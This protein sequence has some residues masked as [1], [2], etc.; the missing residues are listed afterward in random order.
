MVQDSREAP[1]WDGKHLRLPEPARE[2]ISITEVE[3][4]D[5]FAGPLF[6]R[7]FGDPPPAL[8]HH[9]VAFGRREDASLVPVAYAHF[10][11]FGDIALIGGMST[12]G[13][14]LTQLAQ[15]AREAVSQAGGLAL[16]LLHYGFARFSG[17]SAFFGHVGDARAREVDLKAGFRDTQHEH[18][19]VY[20][21]EVLPEWKQKAL[22]AKARSI[23]PF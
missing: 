19:M 4:G 13:Q 17:I 8:P 9:I 7:K 3:D 2:W 16:Y 10:L 5:F 18:L 22:I 11:V 20:F 21:P 6:R 23:G 1:T 12:D 15:A 14:G